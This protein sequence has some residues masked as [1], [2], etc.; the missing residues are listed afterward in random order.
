MSETVKT[1]AIG[2]LAQPK[3]SPVKGSDKLWELAEDWHVCVR[4]IWYVIP[5][6]YRTDGASIPRFLWR[7][8]GHPFTGRRVIPALT[9]DAIYEGVIPFYTREGADRVYRDGLV[10]QGFPK[11]K[12]AVEYTAIR[13]FGKRHWNPSL[14]LENAD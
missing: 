11:W 5:M 8:C 6:G 4:G 1:P 13:W 12:A 9:H 2:Y 14:G 7:V 3:L 10:E